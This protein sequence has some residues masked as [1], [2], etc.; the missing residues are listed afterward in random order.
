MS[1]TS[2]LLSVYMLSNLKRRN[3]PLQFLDNISAKLKGGE[4]FFSAF[5]PY[6]PSHI[7]F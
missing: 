6:G 2:V 4:Y 3:M 7:L 5:I 1:A